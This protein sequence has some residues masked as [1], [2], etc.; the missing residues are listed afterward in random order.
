MGGAPVSKV[1]VADRT[2]D[3]TVRF[4]Q[5]TRNSP[6]ALGK[7]VLTT[8][9]GA[10]IPLSQVAH[11]RLQTGESTITHEMGH[12]ELLVTVDN[13]DRAL[14]DYLTE[15]QEQDRP[16]RAFRPRQVSPRVGRPVREPAARPGT[17]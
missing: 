16:V 8:S 2:Y 7:L 5:E 12:R 9:G 10:Q 15:A 17:A 14:S 13:R 6:E 4:P 3:V 1:Y 11:I